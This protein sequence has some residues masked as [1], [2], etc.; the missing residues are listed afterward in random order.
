MNKK[1]IGVGLLT[2][3]TVVWAVTTWGPFL[4]KNYHPEIG[5]LAADQDVDMHAASNT[6]VLVMNKSVDKIKAGD[7]VRFVYPDGK[8]YDMETEYQ[9]S[10]MRSAACIYKKITP[11]ACVGG[12]THCPAVVSERQIDP[13]RGDPKTSCESRDVTMEF[14]TGY[15]KQDSN[16]NGNQITITASWVDTGTQSVEFAKYYNGGY[17]HCR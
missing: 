14:D 5:S 9:C 4:I 2:A 7:I 6:P 8:V 16:V 1:A 17:P 3:A 13:Y 12:W 15:W 11:V 10:P